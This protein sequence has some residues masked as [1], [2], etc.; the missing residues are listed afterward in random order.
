M[1]H[2]FDQ[3]NQLKQQLA[4][5]DAKAPYVT[6]GDIWWFSLGKNVGSEINGKSDQFS[7]P[8]VIFKKLA[9]HLYFVLPTTTQQRTGT[10]YVPIRH[11]GKNMTV[12]LQQ[13]RIVDA[14][15]IS[16]KIGTLDD[17]DMERIRNGFR[18]LYGI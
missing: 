7:R 13:A 16:S 18:N 3:W 12:C 1:Q 2:E 10:W 4:S 15:R 17:A 14:K 5:R 11:K 6:E 8:A 9:H